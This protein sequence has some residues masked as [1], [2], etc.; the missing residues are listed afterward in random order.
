MQVLAKVD[1]GLRP[2]QIDMVLLVGRATRMPRL[3]SLLTTYL[4][5]DPCK[6]SHEVRGPSEDSPACTTVG[7]T[8]PGPS[9]PTLLADRPRR[10]TGGCSAFSGAAL[11]RT[12]GT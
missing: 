6:L 4:N 12:C 10:A 5:C 8:P 2:E 11:W 3:Q 1:G 7:P 9:Q